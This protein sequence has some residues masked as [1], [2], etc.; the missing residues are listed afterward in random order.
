[1]SSSLADQQNSSEHSSNSVSS[2]L[3]RFA[4]G[5][6]A[7]LCVVVSKSAGDAPGF[8]SDTSLFAVSSGSV[9]G[10]SGAASVAGAVKAIKDINSESQ[11]AGAG[12]SIGGAG[13]TPSAPS[14]NLV[15]GTGTNQIAQGIANQ[16]Q[17]IQAYVTSGAV[18]TAQSLERN[19]IRDASL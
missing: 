12:G 10:D 19:I 6:L 4:S 7:L 14:F 15:Q 3:R 11:S 8:V 18:T 16:R 1:M 17:P 5:F 9:A 13:G 2:A